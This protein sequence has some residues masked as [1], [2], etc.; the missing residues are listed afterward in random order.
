[1]S[2]TVLIL[3]SSLSFLYYGSTFFLNSGMKEEFDRYGLDK[4]RN[5]VGSLQILGGIGLLIGLLSPIIL[6]IS[7]GG[8]A[9][10][11]L[12]GFAV[13]LKMKDGLLLSLPSF[14]FMLLNIYICF[15][16]LK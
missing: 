14:F 4:F 7:S 6:V 9:V 10:L 3:I 1:M 2:I 8:L 12:M 15:Y 13:R 11:M 5:L 16:T